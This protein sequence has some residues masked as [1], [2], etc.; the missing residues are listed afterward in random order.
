MTAGP[1]GDINRL[2]IVGGGTA[3]W[4]AAAALS[5]KFAASGLDITL[6]ESAEIG[7][8]GVGEA[9]LPHIRFFNQTIGI[10]EAELMARTQATFKLG[11]EFVGWGKPDESY[12]HPFGDFGE[13]YHDI[14]FHHLWTKRRLQGDATPLFDYS[15]PVVMAGANRYAMP[16]PDPASL[17]STFGYAFQ[18]D[19]SLYAAYLSELSQQRGVKRIEGKI[20]GA[21]RDGE[22]GNIDHV[23]LENGTKVHG[24]LFVDCSGFRGLL[25][26]QT[27]ETGYDDWSHYLPC[28]RAW[29]VPCSIVDPIGP[30]T[31]ATARQAGWQW[32]IPL[33]HRIGNGHV[34]C[35]EYISD[36]EACAVLLNNLEGEALAEPRQLFFKTG[37]RRKCWNHNVVA[38]GLASG[39]LEPLES[40]SIHLIQEGITALVELF[41]HRASMA[42]DA[43][44][45]N[46]VMELGYDRIRDFLVLHYVANQRHGQKFWDDMRNMTYPESLT[47]KLDGFVNSGIIP[48]YDVGAFMPPSWVA[49]CVGQNVVPQGYDPRVDRFEPHVIADH[50]SQL[51]TRIAQDVNQL[52]THMDFVR[53]CCAG[54]QADAA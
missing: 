28:N 31:R 5:Y 53:S 42:E 11:I 27:L 46:A 48:T 7:T 16:D 19:A 51:R 40:T 24:D 17:L 29:A 18:F 45:Y 33:Q 49:V 8:V 4:M 50:L 3:G 25:I 2:V 35:N 52:G 14:G 34:Y 36:D 10:D 26:E 47:E 12:I 30:Y 38:I 37:R 39:F 41:P 54:V 9:T 20:V 44:E 15:V 43:A 32:R 21:E 13:S 1:T 6:I 22:S 23:V